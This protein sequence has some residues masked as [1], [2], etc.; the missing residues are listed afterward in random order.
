VRKQKK[1][2][3]WPVYFDSSK[4]RKEGRKVPK[5]AAVSNPSLTEVQRASER[6][7]LK[8]DVDGDAAHSAIP[9]RKT[10]RIWV[11]TRG[12]KTKVLMKIATET[13]TIRQQMTD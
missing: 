13:A 12:T 4:T 11:Q 7:G 2:I 3:I 6:L 10:G 5:N 8:P 9:W 1:T